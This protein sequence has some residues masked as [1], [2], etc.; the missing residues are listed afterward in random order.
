M[1]SKELN[2]I[3]DLLTEC[4]DTSSNYVKMRILSNDKQIS[5]LKSSL[6]EKG[7]ENINSLNKERKEK[8][9]LIKEYQK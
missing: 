5:V 7:E 6:G 3:I 9:L 4:V 1:A 2:E 8:V